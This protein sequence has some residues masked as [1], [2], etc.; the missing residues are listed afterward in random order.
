MN[1]N[2]NNE[3]YPKI[4]VNWYPGHMTKTKRQLEDKLKL[5]DLLVEVVDARAPISTR[6]P[7]FS[8][9]FKNKKRIVVL[10]KSDMANDSTTKEW[11]KYFRAQGIY[12]VAYSAV[13][14]NPAILK[15][16]I[17]KAA[18]DIYEKYT[19]KGMK[20]TVRAVVAGIPNVGKSAIL[21]RLLGG[22]KLKEGNKPG[23][24][25]GLQWVKLTPYLELM[26]SP[27]MLWPKIEDEKSGAI[28]A[29]IGSIRL[30]IL[31]EEQL[32]Y[33]L[34]LTLKKMEPDMLLERYK[35]DELAE[36]PWDI[37][38][39]ICRKRGFLLKK[40]EY[41]YERGAKTLLEE[42]R[43]GKMGRISLEQPKGEC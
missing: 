14:G 10:N 26:D 24:T 41:D 7:D 36:D 39:D 21:N 15:K 37:M 33:Y 2:D 8:P 5:I 17:E 34:L 42:F 4:S 6:N 40:G 29:I 25:R 22:K 38:G 28:I 18:E 9:M 12:A 32:A 19:E 1:K 16:E 20:K 11:I 31:D 35:L 43:N 13:S 3:I 27:G 23:V 30:E